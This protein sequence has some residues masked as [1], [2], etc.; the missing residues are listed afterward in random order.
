MNVAGHNDKL[1]VL[2]QRLLEKAR[3]LEIKPDRLEVI[4][5]E[6]SDYILS[7]QIVF[8]NEYLADQAGMGEL[9]LGPDVHT[10]RVLW[11]VSFV[12]RPVHIIRQ[13]R[14]HFWWAISRS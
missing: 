2:L 7:N 5:E 3:N 9:L 1:D 4:K 8:V 13:G 12:G 10:I 14:Y 11:K 6:V